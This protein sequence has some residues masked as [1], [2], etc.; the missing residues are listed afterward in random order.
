MGFCGDINAKDEHIE[1]GI[2]DTGSGWLDWG[3]MEGLQTA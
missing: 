1:A 2:V 3:E